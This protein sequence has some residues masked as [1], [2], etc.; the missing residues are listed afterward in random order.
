MYS[1]ADG[2]GYIATD[3]LF[4]FRQI[5]GGTPAIR[6]TIF[7]N[8]KIVPHVPLVPL[9]PNVPQNRQYVLC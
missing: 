1:T 2:R 4:T 7:C 9:V 3:F 6:Q 5:V 8:K